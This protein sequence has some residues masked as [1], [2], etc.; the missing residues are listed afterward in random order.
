LVKNFKF[1]CSNPNFTFYNLLWFC[2]YF[3]YY[4]FE[5]SNCYYFITSF[6]L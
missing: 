3:Y 6:I 5:K 1:S 2:Y 4:Y